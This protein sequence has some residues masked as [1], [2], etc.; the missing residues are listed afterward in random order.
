MKRQQ[1]LPKQ[2]P[3]GGSTVIT[4][5]LRA[6][7]QKKWMDSIHDL[8]QP[9]P[10]VMPLVREVVHEINLIDPDYKPTYHQPRCPDALRGE[11]AKKIKRYTKAG[12]WQ[13]ASVQSAVPM[14]CVYKKD[15]HLRT[16]IDSRKC[17]DNTIKDVTPF[18]DQDKIRNDVAR[19]KFRMKLDMSDAY[20]QMRVKESDV[21][22]MAFATIIGTYVSYV[23][24]QGDCNAPA[25]FQRFMIYIFRNEVGR[26]V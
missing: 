11:F 22:K 23:M 4:L 3:I 13:S 5:E 1:D 7:L 2:T 12:W 16:I 20:E 25:T 6:S 18:P 26:F 14:I 15:R 21:M 9:V 19:A 17:N 10:L 8:V 24:Q